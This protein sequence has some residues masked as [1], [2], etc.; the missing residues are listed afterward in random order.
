MGSKQLLVAVFTALQCCTLFAVPGDEQWNQRFSSPIGGEIRSIVVRNG[1]IYAAG[2]FTSA[3]DAG[4]TH[5]AKWNGTDWSALSGLDGPGGVTALTTNDNGIYATGPNLWVQ[6]ASGYVSAPVARWD[7]SAYSAFGVGLSLIGE[8]IAAMH[9]SGNEL[10]IAGYFLVNGSL[11]TIAR[12]TG[13][14]WQSIG[15]SFPFEQTFFAITKKGTDLFVAGKFNWT[16]ATATNV[17]RWNGT[18]WFALGSGLN[19]S[20]RA[21]AVIGNDIY[22]GGDFTMA[23]GVPANRV[24]KWNGSTWSALGMG[25]NGN[26]TTLTVIGTD[27]YA[28]G[29]FS[30]AGGVSSPKLAKWNGSTWTAVNVQINGKIQTSASLGTDIYVGGKIES[31]N[32]TNVGNIFSY[33]SSG[34]WKKLKSG[35]S[36]GE[37]NVLR[38][39]GND[40]Y[41]GGSWRNLAGTNC[42]AIA[43]FDG[44]TWTGL[45]SG[46]SHPYIPAI[47]YDLIPRSNEVVVAGEFEMAGSVAVTNVA[48]WNGTNWQTLGNG[49]G[50]YGQVYALA[51]RGN[52]LFAGGSFSGNSVQNIARLN[53]STWVSVGTSSPNGYVSA[54]A[55]LGNDLYVGGS[56]SSWP[57]SGSSHLAKWNGSSWSSVGSAQLNGSVEAL[58]VVGTNLYVG[59]YFTMIGGGTF[60]RIAKWNGTAWSTVGS[61]L[62]GA[63]DTIL[64]VGNDLYVGGYFSTA[65]G[66][67]ANR[68]AKWN[69]TSWSGMGG[70]IIGTDFPVV[71]TIVA[72]GND[73][74][75]GGSFTRA[76]GL[77]SYNLAGW[78]I[79]T[80]S[81]LMSNEGAGVS[82][83][84]PAGVIPYKLQT[85]TNVNAS[86]WIDVPQITTISNGNLSVLTN[87]SS[88]SR[89]FRLNQ[90]P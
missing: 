86:T 59:G 45:G 36:G 7:G 21:L 47:V 58:T 87:T 2:S 19:D 41:A 85:A 32:N 60:N 56:F 27:L 12:G 83:S 26:V 44:L 28:G 6:T 15:P 76:G 73:L 38:T 39:I 30:T 67:S 54:M 66:I 74:L 20:A 81:L 70:G 84:W 18:N 90:T 11:S 65:G 68:I 46:L 25:M 49:L 48:R 14:L 33:S 57:V 62:N 10:Y 79:A 89:F 72:K 77:P 17:A 61:G 53:G 42:N 69:G 3:D 51:Q 35:V 9:G 8:E 23:G 5:F 31:V 50:K 37:V 34:N 16:G 64:P 80:P 1:E 75:V 71:R 43:R 52:E 63:V 22:V 40:I 82:V 29:D 13:G 78:R 24:A 4:A 55:A 88:S